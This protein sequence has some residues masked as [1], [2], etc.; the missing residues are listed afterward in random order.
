MRPLTISFCVEPEPT[1]RLRSVA[2]LVSTQVIRGVVIMQQ[3]FSTGQNESWTHM[4]SPL[5]FPRISAAFTT[6]SYSLSLYSRIANIT[7]R[8]IRGKLWIFS[9]H[10]PAIG[11]HSRCCEET[12][13]QCK[14]HEQLRRYVHLRND[15]WILMSAVR[16][17]W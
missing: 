15:L 7:A 16:L 13:A 1:L 10:P 9:N 2:S 11:A 3:G 8:D 4:H 17:T 6:V 5:E 14:E 12:G